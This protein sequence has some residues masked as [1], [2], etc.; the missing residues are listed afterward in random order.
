MLWKVQVREN[1]VERMGKWI[2]SI[3]ILYL[4]LL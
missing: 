1:V 3:R 4:S 2:L